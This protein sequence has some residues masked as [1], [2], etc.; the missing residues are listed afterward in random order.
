MTHWINWIIGTCIA[1]GFLIVAQPLVASG[2]AKVGG[3]FVN[4]DEATFKVSVDSQW[5]SGAWQRSSEIDYIY[6]ESNNIET[7]NEFYGS[8]KTNYTFQTLSL[9]KVK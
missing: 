2:S 7:L 1:I 5:E 8:F 6:K 9:Y 4:S 3:T